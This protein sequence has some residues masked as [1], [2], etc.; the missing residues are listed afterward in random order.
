MALHCAECT[1]APS[2]AREAAQEVLGPKRSVLKPKSK[3]PAKVAKHLKRDLGKITWAD[4]KQAV[5]TRVLTERGGRCEWQ[6]ERLCDDPH[7]LISGSGKKRVFEA[8]NTVAGICREHHRLYE[9]ADIETLL[10]AL[11]WAHDHRFH[12]A[13]AE[14]TRRLD[15][16]QAVRDATPSLIRKTV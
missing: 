7:H 11:V 14:I 6:C 9:K 13:H 3:R 1:D 16:A 12:L 5:R 2:A 10:R 4:V 8:P 15:K